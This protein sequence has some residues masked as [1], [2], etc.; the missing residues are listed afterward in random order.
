MRAH[1]RPEFLNRVDDIVVF[2]PL[3]LDEI[4]QI[5]VLLTADLRSRL[6]E[7]EIGLELDDAAIELAAREG[8]DPVYGAR[9]LKRFLQHQLETKIGRAMIGGEVGPG[10]V[11]R[12]GVRDG[13]FE[14]A[15]ESPTIDD[16]SG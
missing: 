9:P 4:R 6:A 14:I 12:V 1:F 2:T 10:A 15:I 8:Y 5:V 13:E 11:V 3:S 7:R 16:P